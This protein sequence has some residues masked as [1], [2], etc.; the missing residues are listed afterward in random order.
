VS[1]TSIS[2]CKGSR[3]VEY[4]IPDFS[5]WTD[6][7]GYQ[8]MPTKLTREILAAAITGFEQQ[9]K[10]LDVEIAEL[11]RMLSPASTDGAAPEPTALKRK[12]SAAARRRIA[13]AQRAR[14]AEARRKA[15]STVKSATP[16]KKKRRL[17]G[18]EGDYRGDQKTL[19][20]G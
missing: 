20:G 9:K 1:S 19:G 5:N 8:R 3:T 6:H 4:F 14:W 15:G 11:R 2:P 12:V 7:D 18:A 16:A 13:A 10:R 17:S